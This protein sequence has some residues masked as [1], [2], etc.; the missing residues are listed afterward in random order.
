M[1]LDASTVAATLDVFGGLPAGS[2]LAFDTPHR[3]FGREGTVGDWVLRNGRGFV[4]HRKQDVA[5]FPATALDF[6][7]EGLESNFVAFV[8]AERQQLF[9][10]VSRAEGAFAD[11]QLLRERLELLPH[12]IRLS[13]HLG[14]SPA[15]GD[16]DLRLE[17]MLH[18]LRKSAGSLPTQRQLER[19]YFRNLLD[20]CGGRIEGAQG[21][22]R[23]A[24]VKPS[25]LRSRMARIL[26]EE[27]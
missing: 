3:R 18:E 16:M 9:F 26:S 23:I 15:A 11:E 19:A 1:Y 10:A 6:E 2:R 17:G 4:G 20:V 21:A 25:T 5:R 13:D 12:F 7:D 14:T 24:G 22:A 27:G 8:D